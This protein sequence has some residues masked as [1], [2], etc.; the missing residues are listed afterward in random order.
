MYGK[1]ITHNDFDGI[2]SGAICSVALG[3]IKIYFA[4][5]VTITKSLIPITENDI[6]CDLPYPLECA[7]WFDHHDGNLQDLHYRKIDPSTIRGRHASLKSCARVVFEYFSEREKLPEFI[8]DA[9]KE[10]DIIDS[11][12]YSSIEEW[13]KESPGKIIDNT[14]KVSGQTKRQKE[15]YMREILLLLAERSIEEVAGTP[16]VMER[17]KRYK[18]E[19]EGMLK[20]IKDSLAFMPMDEARE[21]ILLDLTR[22]NKRPPLTKNLAYL[23]Y[24][25]A[26]AVLQISSLFDRG[27]KT[28]NLSFSMSLSINT[29]ST[30]H[31]KD[32]GEIMRT[33]NLGDG[34]KGAGAGTLQCT[35][36][37]EMLR[38][39][40]KTTEEIFR[41]WKGQTGKDGL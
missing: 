15:S 7:L 30:E 9:V 18:Q 13:R 31:S 10:A 22:Y 39:K 32:I 4:G 14:L 2:V 25:S 27:V 36:K 1:I 40:K 28:N 5:P 11:F 38:K 16:K 41:L 33:L 26:L 19:E 6:V 20:I 34:H 37:Q 24:P 12:G 17:F 23:F 3:V 21:I 35:S 8:E 29:N